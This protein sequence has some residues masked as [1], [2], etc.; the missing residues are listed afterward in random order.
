[1]WMDRGRASVKVVANWAP[2]MGF[3]EFASP[4]LFLDS[5]IRAVLGETLYTLERTCILMHS[6]S[7]EVRFR[8]AILTSWL[9][10]KHM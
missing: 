10:L 6:P 1:M 7:E 2:Y 8:L 3:H 9:Y 5:R 4:M